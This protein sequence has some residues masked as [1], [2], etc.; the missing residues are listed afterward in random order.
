MSDH[1]KWLA[2]V[3]EET[4]EPALPIIDPHHHLWHFKHPDGEHRYL[5]EDLWEVHRQR[6]CQSRLWHLLSELFYIAVS[7]R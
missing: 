3:K 4:L 2:Q 1:D 7:W 6:L 5:L